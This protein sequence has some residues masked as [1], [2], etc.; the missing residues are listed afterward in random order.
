MHGSSKTTSSYHSSFTYQTFSRQCTRTTTT[1]PAV[2]KVGSQTEAIVRPGSFFSTA[3]TQTS[4]AAPG[5]SVTRALKMVVREG[6]SATPVVTSS[7]IIV[8]AN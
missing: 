3:S 1:K 6:R 5:I 7:V 2:V 8:S 4:I